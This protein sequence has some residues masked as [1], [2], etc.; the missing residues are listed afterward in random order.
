MFLM[1]SPFFFINT[2]SS[3][4]FLDA[5]AAENTF[6]AACRTRCK[7]SFAAGGHLE[8]TGSLVFGGVKRRA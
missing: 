8:F 2:I 3:F 5:S 7:R 4:F 6:E 1:V